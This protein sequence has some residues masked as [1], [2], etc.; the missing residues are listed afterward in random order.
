[1]ACD[2][3][4]EGDTLLNNTFGGEAAEFSPLPGVGVE[5]VTNVAIAGLAI[6]G[7]VIPKLVFVTFKAR[8][9]VKENALYVILVLDDILPETFI[10]LPDAAGAAEPVQVNVVPTKDTTVYAISLLE[11]ISPAVTVGPPDTVNV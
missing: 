10:K 8:P 9:E 6:A 3:V 5:I 4:T 11:Y 1:M 2:A 7:V